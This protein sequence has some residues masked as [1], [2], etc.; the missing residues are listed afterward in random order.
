MAQKT[1]Q[2]PN[3]AFIGGIYY[4]PGEI[5]VCD[6]SKKSKTFVEVQLAAPPVEYVPVAEPVVQPA[7]EAPLFP[8]KK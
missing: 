7:I 8:R 5:I 4:A 3:G 6:E 1:Y 2:A